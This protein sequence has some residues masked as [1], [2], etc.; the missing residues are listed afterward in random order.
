[1]SHAWSFSAF[2]SI[3]QELG[4]Y[5]YKFELGGTDLVIIAAAKQLRDTWKRLKCA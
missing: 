5:G 3:S 1:M 4:V 2:A